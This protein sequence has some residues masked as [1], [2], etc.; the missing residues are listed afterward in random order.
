MAKT[1][2][3]KL[4]EKQKEKNLI[5]RTW[6]K[7]KTWQTKN[8]S[9][10]INPITNKK[11]FAK[12]Y[13]GSKHDLEKVK[14]DAKYNISAAVA[15]SVYKARN[16]LGIYQ[17]NNYQTIIHDIRQEFANTREAAAVFEDDII[18]YI[19]AMRTVRKTPEEIKSEV[20]NYFF[21]S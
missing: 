12:I 15:R 5:D 13:R 4:T 21:G 10:V 8:R 9:D 11:D 3:K 7:Y 20:G 18:D 14:I 17:G 6:K 16:R 19:N 2:H 1:K